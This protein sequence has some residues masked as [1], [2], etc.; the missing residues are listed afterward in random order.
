ML[1]AASKLLEACEYEM[2][3]RV[4]W[5][6]LKLAVDEAATE[7]VE[8]SDKMPVQI[9][10]EDGMILVWDKDGDGIDCHELG[11]A[12]DARSRKPSGRLT[13]GPGNTS[14][15]SRMSNAN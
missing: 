15:M 14:S 5:D 10:F 12:D 2:L 13:A 4:E 1:A 7:S 3:T 11:G 6:A 9:L 8:P